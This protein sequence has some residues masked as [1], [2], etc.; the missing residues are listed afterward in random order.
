MISPK[1]II[2]EAA[3]Y[4]GV[5]ESP[6]NSN[7]VIFN[8]EYY[9]KEVSG[10]NYPW[11]CTYVW[12]VFKHAGASNLFCG[13]QKTAYTPTA[14]NY[15]KSIGRWYSTPKVGD[16]VFFSFNASRINHIGI[17]VEVISPSKIKTIEGNTSTGNDRNGGTVMYRERSTKNIVGYGRPKYDTQDKP[18]DDS[19][20]KTFITDC[21]KVFGVDINGIADRKLLNATIT[22]SEKIN[23]THP[24]VRVLQ[25][26]FN[27]IGCNCG[28]VDGE[29]GPK[30]T[31]AVKKYQSQ[32]SKKPDGI[33][34]AK[35]T[36]WQKLLRLA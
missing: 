11:C 6:P 32:F 33:I 23:N 24:I 8:T 19:S 22:V 34:D 15:Y 13:G 14:A 29:A 35:Q 28:K 16:L 21:Q 1:T 27:S 26:Y 25:T 17:V 31:D 4:V 2:N 10:A 36:T 18:K 7:K 20:Y 5:F 30:F 9:G 12:Y 3:K